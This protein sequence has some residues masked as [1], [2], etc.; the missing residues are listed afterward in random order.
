MSAGLKYI[1]VDDDNLCHE[2]SKM[3]MEDALG[4]VDIKS[5]TK[6]MEA[7]E[8][9]EREYAKNLGHTVLFLDINMPRMNGWEFLEEFEKFSGD[10]KQQFN[11]YMFSSSIDRLDKN[12]AEANINVEGF[13]SKPLDYE[14]LTHIAGKEF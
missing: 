13:I 3:I 11:I 5:F 9:I 1:I 8:F 14:I 10:I 7:L 4:E 6:P 12:R 2:V